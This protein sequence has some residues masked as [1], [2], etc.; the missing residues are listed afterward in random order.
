MRLTAPAST[1]QLD[2]GLTVLRA[3]TGLIFAAHGA[4]KL[5]VFGFDGVAGAFGGMGVPLPGIVGP[6]VALVEF[7]G[8]LAL[9]VGLLTRLASAGLAA[10]MLGAI[11]LVHLSAGFFSPNGIEFPLALA[12]AAVT[13]ILTGA[14]RWSLDGRLAG[15]VTEP[16]ADV[17]P[18]RRAA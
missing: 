2:L 15:R 10:T 18:M 9:I 4:Q 8:G 7:F 17:R 11:T 6:A 16:S 14:G 12:G 13:L 1:R 3:V 5:F